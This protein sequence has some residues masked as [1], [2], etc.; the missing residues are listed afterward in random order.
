MPRTA[1]TV[2]DVDHKTGVNP[3][4]WTAWDGVNQHEFLNTQGDV[5]LLL[6]NDDATG[7][8]I[9]VISQAVVDTDLAVAD[10]VYAVAAGDTAAF[11]G[12][13]VSVYNTTSNL[14][15]IDADSAT[16]LFVAVIRT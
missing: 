11:S 12:F 4:V 15:E 1:L 5:T 10:P 14:V 16:S 7:K 13:P 2:Q 3:I 6:R 9:T 8:N